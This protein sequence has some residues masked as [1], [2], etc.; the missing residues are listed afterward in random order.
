[1][2]KGNYS[3]GTIIM[4]ARAI[5]PHGQQAARGTPIKLSLHANENRCKQTKS[6]T[7]FCQTRLDLCREGESGEDGGRVV[8]TIMAKGRER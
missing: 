4:T 2:K 1:M 7:V 5:V 3:W 6:V 8:N